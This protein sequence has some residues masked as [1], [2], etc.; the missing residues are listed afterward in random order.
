MGRFKKNSLPKP[1]VYKILTE[2]VELGIK[3]GWNHAHKHSDAPSENHIKEQ[4]E[5]CV[6]L[7]ISEYFKF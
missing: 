6:M 1:D 2:C 7:N 3:S 5:H 4:I